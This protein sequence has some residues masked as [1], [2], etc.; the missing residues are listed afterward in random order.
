MPDVEAYA[1]AWRLC[2]V[3]TRVIQKAIMI[4]KVPNMYHLMSLPLTS[5]IMA[6]GTMIGHLAIFLQ[7]VCSL[8]SGDCLQ[9][10][11]GFIPVLAVLYQDL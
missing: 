3:Q 2:R 7:H 6:A 8:F 10:S 5:P 9:V 1:G 4:A 11:Q